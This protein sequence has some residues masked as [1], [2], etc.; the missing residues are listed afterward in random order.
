MSPPPGTARGWI[1]VSSRL[2]RGDQSLLLNH[3]FR[4]TCY[5]SAP[6]PDTNECVGNPCTGAY[7]VCADKPAPQTGYTCNCN[8]ALG[9]VRDAGSGL[10]EC[11]PGTQLVNGVCQ[12]EL[13]SAAGLG[14]RRKWCCCGAL[15]AARPSLAP[16]WVLLQTSTA[17]STI[18]APAR[19]RARTCLRRGLATSAPAPAWAQTT[20][21]RAAPALVRHFYKPARGTAPKRV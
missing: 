13:C 7:E 20:R 14:I 8:S 21:I 6:A 2:G 17:A 12:G 5:L 18:S 3:A 4:A 15:S 11:G 9:F 19:A 16:S 10:C 1:I